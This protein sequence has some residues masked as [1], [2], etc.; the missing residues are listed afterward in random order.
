MD[1]AKYQ[2]CESIWQ[3]TKVD[4]EDVVAMGLV[5][6]GIESGF[7]TRGRFAPAEEAGPH[8]FHRTVSEHLLGSS[9]A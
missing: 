5:Q 3:N 6:R 4:D 1:Q 8:W 9:P 7:A 2:A